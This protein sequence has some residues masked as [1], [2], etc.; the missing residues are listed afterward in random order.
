MSHIREDCYFFVT[1]KKTMS[2]VCLTCHKKEGQGW[3]WEGKKKGYGDY[4]LKCSSC[5]NILH[6]RTEVYDD[7]T[8]EAQASV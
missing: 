5:G 2:A 3:F 4:D 7:E 6:Q 1:E 8:K